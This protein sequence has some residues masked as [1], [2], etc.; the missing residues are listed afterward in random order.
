MKQLIVIYEF[1][2][3]NDFIIRQ[4]FDKIRTYGSFAFITKTSCIVWTNQPVLK[5]RNFLMSGLNGND[6]IF[7]SEISAP[8]AWSNSIPKEVSDYIINNLKDV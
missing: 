6:K 2:N 5:V 4:F 3:V 8:A 7:V 1:Q